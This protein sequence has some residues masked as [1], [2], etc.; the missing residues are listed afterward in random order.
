MQG[1]R[2]MARDN[3]RS[4]VPPGGHPAGAASGAADEVT[5]D[6]D[7]NGI[8]NARA[9][10]KATGSSRTSPSPRRPA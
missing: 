1:E 10:D 5:F 2:P 9:Q 4:E 7:A 6:I 3:G 8:L